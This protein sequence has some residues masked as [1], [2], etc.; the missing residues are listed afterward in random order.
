MISADLRVEGFDSRSFGN[1]VGLFA[2]QVMARHDRELAPSDDPEVDASDELAG[3]SGTLVIVVS[4][5]GAVL[6]A[7]HTDV[8]RIRGLERAEPHELPLLAERF[9]A[10]RCVRL[11]EGAAEEITERIA[12]RIERDDDYVA[13]WLV[14]ARA[15]REAIEGGLVSVWPRPLAAVPIPTAGMVRRAL[16]TVLP[17]ERALVIML[18]SAQA[19]WTA[20]V[21]RRRR[22][23]VDLLAGPDLVARWTGPL[24][25]D[26][27]R[28]HRIVTAAIDEHVAPVHLGI[29]GDIASVRRLLRSAEPG[30]W[31][32][33]VA[34]REII[35]Q[36]SPPY[37]AV[38]LGAVAARAVADR[39]ARA[40]G[41]FDA[42]RALAP[43][44]TYVRGRVAEIASVTSTL[45]FDPLAVL[46]GILAR[47]D[48]ASAE[49]PATKRER[50]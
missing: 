29:Y 21:L 25:G 11:V 19:P 50:E 34:T 4:A 28:D 2:P 14:I 15:I 24:G 18:W 8:G 20:A 33:A 35:V 13:Q 12:I 48:D 31:A 22:G 36:P 37:V 42:L 9:H 26:W 1:L 3:A 6:K 46:A 30:A 5:S 47:V 49:G 45:G 44:A 32:E 41:G 43:L 23:D 10:R 16:D 27:R 39:S 17:D 40:L 7:L 38:A